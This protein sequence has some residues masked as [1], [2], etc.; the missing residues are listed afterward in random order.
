VKRRLLDDLVVILVVLGVAEH[1]AGAVDIPALDTSLELARAR[2]MKAACQVANPRR[3]PNGML[4][5]W[6]AAIDVVAMGVV[7]FVC[8]YTGE[9]LLELPRLLTVLIVIIG[10]IALSAASG[11]LVR[12]LDARLEAA[13]LSPDWPGE[14]PVPEAVLGEDVGAL[15]TRAQGLVDQLAVQRLA[16][17]AAPIRS[18]RAAQWLGR[19]DRFLQHLHHV[20]AHLCGARWVWLRHSQD[21]AA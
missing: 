7:A 18:G 2:I 13:A 17:V 12:R 6:S 8:A 21:V 1:R 10:Q 15:L 3:Q 19:H 11:P 16:R 14:Q 20:D 4:R 9:V 5:Y